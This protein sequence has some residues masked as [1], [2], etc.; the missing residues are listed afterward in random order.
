V[1]AWQIAEPKIGDSNAEKIF[2]AVSNG[3]E[4]A[5]N[6]PIYSL[7]QNNA[8]TR[9]GESAKPHNFRALAIKKN[10]AE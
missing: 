6:L 7:T 1:P 5:P 8:Q 9:R 4:H 2:N 3:L 10:S